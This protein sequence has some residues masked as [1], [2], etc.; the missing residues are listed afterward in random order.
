MMSRG[1]P[2]F[3]E[4]KVKVTSQNIASMSADLF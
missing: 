4:S 2:F 1:N 3:L